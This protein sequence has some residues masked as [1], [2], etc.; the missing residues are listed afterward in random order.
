LR[1][2][3]PLSI[4]NA[5]NIY[6]QLLLLIRYLSVTCLPAIFNQSN[7]SSQ[8]T[9]LIFIRYR[10][11]FVLISNFLIAFVPVRQAQGRL[12][13]IPGN[14]DLRTGRGISLRPGRKLWPPRSRRQIS[15]AVFGYG[16]GI[17]EHA[18]YSNTCPREHLYSVNGS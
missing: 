12:W 1:F 3:A 8:T 16:L 9:K 14:S 5:D 6:S 15:R 18:I 2:P 17:S 10:R 11:Q 7:N 4:N 13:F